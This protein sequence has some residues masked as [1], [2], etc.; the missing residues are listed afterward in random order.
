MTMIH[1]PRHLRHRPLL[2]PGGGRRLPVQHPRGVGRP[3]RPAAGPR[4]A[5]RSRQ[6]GR[7]GGRSPPRRARG[8]AA[9]SPAARPGSQGGATKRRGPG[10]GRQR[11]QALTGG[12][13]GSLSVPLCPTRPAGPGRG[14]R[15][16]SRLPLPLLS[17]LRC[18][19][20]AR[21]AAGEG[22][23]R[24]GGGRSR[25]VRAGLGEQLPRCGPGGL[26]REAPLQRPGAGVVPAP[27]RPG[28]AEGAA[29]GGAEGAGPLPAAAGGHLSPPPPRR[30][31]PPPRP[32][33]SAASSSLRS[34]SSSRLA[35][36]AAAPAARRG[37]LRRAGA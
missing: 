25:A 22:A 30:R 13:R 9:G 2:Q 17:S 16:V 11:R 1:H 8:A 37:R 34:S 29:Q 12:R 24:R 18:F 26:R 35:A 14:Q 32:A 3:L 4:Q 15:A 21:L 10:S 33:A 27:S 20:R 6:P 5:K 28:R 36:V 7:A 19:P 31:V 23:V